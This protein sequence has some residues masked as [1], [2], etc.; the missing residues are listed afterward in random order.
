[1]KMNNRTIKTTVN[2]M[3]KG[4]EIAREIAIK[5]AMLEYREGEQKN[6]EDTV[7]RYNKQFQE[8]SS[9][10][11]TLCIIS[12]EGYTENMSEFL[13][14]VQSDLNDMYISFVDDIMYEVDNEDRE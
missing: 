5:V 1:M 2:N 12:S 10:A 4:M 9:I 8:A 7:N 3:V 6:A 11:S 14:K 13:D